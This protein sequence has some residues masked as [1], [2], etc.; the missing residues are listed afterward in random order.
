ML[1]VVDLFGLNSNEALEKLKV[2]NGRFISGQIISPRRQSEIRAL[3]ITGQNPYCAILACSDSR[4][5]PEIIFDQGIGD[6][7][8]VRLAGNVA[9]ESAIESLAFASDVLKISLIVVVGHQNCGAVNAAW[10][11]S[12]DDDL[13]Q[14]ATLIEPALEGKGTLQEATIAN[15]RAQVAVLNAQPI[16]KKRIN[17]KNLRI[18]GAYYD[19]ES[20]KVNFF[21]VT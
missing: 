9:S 7:F 17:Q 11:H 2:G 1:S 14:I 15:V 5:A 16:L 21:E 18:L 10:Q 3:Y 8:V 13:G 12:A 19:F 20:G 6:L 4:V